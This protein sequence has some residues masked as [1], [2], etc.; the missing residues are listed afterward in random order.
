MTGERHKGYHP[1][2]HRVALSIIK[3]YVEMPRLTFKNTIEK[4]EKEKEKFEKQKY[5][6]MRKLLSELRNALK[7][8]EE[9]DQEIDKALTK[10]FNVHLPSGFLYETKIISNEPLEIKRNRKRIAEI[11]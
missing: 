5:I 10:L 7:P 4:E 1:D 11:Q 9:D 8:N 2:I 6:R 3:E